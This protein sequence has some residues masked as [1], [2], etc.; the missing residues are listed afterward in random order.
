MDK[1]KFEFPVTIYGQLEKYNEVLSKARLRVFYKYLNRNSTF[2]TDEFADKLLSS[3]SYAPVK[4]IYSNSDED[5]LDHGAARDLGRIYGIVPENPNLAW[6]EHLDKD[7]VTRLYACVDVLIFTALYKEAN[8]IVGKSHS[9]ELYGPSLQY[10]QAI[11]NGSRCIVFD[12]GCFLGLQVLGNNVEPCFEGSSFY[13]LQ[14]Q[15]ENI[16]YS[17]K[18]PGGK[19]MPKNIFKLSDGQKY[20]MIFHLLNTEFNEEGGW[21]ISYGIMDVY[22]EYALCFNYETGKYYRAYYTKDDANDMVELNAM[23]QVF[24]LDVTES[25]LNTINTLRALNGD[26][27]ELV[28]EVLTNAQKNADENKEFSCKIEELNEKVSTLEQEKTEI[29]GKVEEYTT[30]INEKDTLISNLEEQNNSLN[31]YKLNVE[32]SKKEAILSEYTNY[33]PIEMIS[34]YREKFGELSAEELDMHLAY[35]LKKT[36]N[37]I[38][39]KNSNDGFVPKDTEPTGIIAVLSKYKK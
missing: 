22:D 39:D 6:E 8:D 18:N 15:I 3:I 32:N 21:T 26:T 23:K 24:I 31:E 25:E 19:E 7:G 14:Q 35:E 27:Y 13:T 34:S 5:F 20:N 2:I 28:N 4:G 9:M 36:G 17:L 38:F 37:S 1:T 10:H 33:L 16:I 30:Q 29:E 11:I 12:E